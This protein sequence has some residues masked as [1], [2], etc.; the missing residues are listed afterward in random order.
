MIG[1]LIFSLILFFIL[2]AFYLFNE[3]FVR[4]D[5]F[6]VTKTKLKKGGKLEKYLVEVKTGIKY[7]NNSSYEWVYIQ[8]YDGLR[9][10]GRYF[11]NKSLNKF[12]ILFHGYRSIAENDFGAI[13]KLYYELGYNILLVDQR[14]SRK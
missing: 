13:F 9:L 14:S 1:I 5:D 7:I 8:S 4:R 2:I 10:A 11:K 3:G 6:D 12:I